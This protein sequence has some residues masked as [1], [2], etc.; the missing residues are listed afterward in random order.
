MWFAHSTNGPRSQWEL[1]RDHLD[2]VSRTASRFASK[3]GAGALGEAMGLLHDIGKY[4]ET[5][6]RRLAGEAQLPPRAAYMDDWL[7]VLVGQCAKAFARRSLF[8]RKWPRGV[9]VF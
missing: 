7:I 9:Q 3:F 6:L 5:F 2:S 1:L 8:R 4:D